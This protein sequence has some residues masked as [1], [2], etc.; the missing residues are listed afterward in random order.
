[1]KNANIV[2]LVTS[3]TQNGFCS[4]LFPVA[5]Y[6]LHE[7]LL[8]S[9]QPYWIGKPAQVVD[10][11]RDLANG[12]H[13]LHNFRPLAKNAEETERITKY[14]YHHDIKPRNI[15]VKGTRLI[16]ADFGLSRLKDVNEDTKT[17]WKNTQP[18]YGAPEA[19]DP[20]TLQERNIGRAYDI[21]SFGCVLSE[22]ATYAVEG[23][24]A[25]KTFRKEREKEGIYGNDN[26]F[27]HDG[28]VSPAVTAWYQKMGDHH[29][30]SSLSLLFEIS[31]KLLIGDPNRRHKSEE[32]VQE[33]DY[34]SLSRW[35]QCVL[36]NTHGASREGL[37]TVYLAKLTLE[38][39]RLQAWGYALG[40]KSFDQQMQPW[41]DQTSDNY[42]R[43][44]EVLKSCTT[45]LVEFMNQHNEPDIQQRVL[46]LL[47]S[48][49]DSLL[50]GLPGS[51]EIT[52]ENTFQLFTVKTGKTVQLLVDSAKNPNSSTSIDCVA[53]QD[54]STSQ[55]REAGLL[56]AARYISLMLT[57]DG[58]LASEKTVQII[59]PSLIGNEPQ[60]ATYSSPLSIRWYY[61]GFR[62]SD[63]QRVVVEER[64][65]DSK[66][67]SIPNEEDFAD[68]GKEVFD[69]VKELAKL[70]Q[71]QP[72]PKDMRVLDCLGVYHL[73]ASTKFGF[74]YE[75]PRLQQEERD[76]EPVSL[77]DLI[78]DTK[79]P[80]RNPTLD[81]KFAL[82]QAIASCIHSLH[83]TGWLHKSICSS[84]LIYFNKPGQNL[85]ELKLPGPYLTGFQ[86]SRQSEPG[87][88]S[89]GSIP[90][91]EKAFIHPSY[92]ENGVGFHSAFD[93]YSLG[94]ILL[95]IA[96]WRPVDKIIVPE[97]SAEKTR[98]LLF[99]CATTYIPKRMGTGY[100]DVVIA[101]LNF[102]DNH[103]NEK[104]ESSLL[105][106]FQQEV[107]GKLQKASLPL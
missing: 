93:Y 42:A 36:S 28:E 107:L 39:N 46:D 74:V 71:M 97:S 99:E 87:A 32:L 61:R 82:S 81:D 75:F 15:L 24:A 77:T 31:S 62:E 27:H 14:G 72:K 4:L 6:D 66:W 5:D 83:L 1:M 78:R 34:A 76:L 35:L 50:L 67:T 30:S 55:H 11:L 44:R 88:Y 25:V 43:V 68:R 89:D 59:D 45:K 41:I 95:E 84:K 92:Q 9:E 60:D 10:S 64:S 48:T 52:I 90:T 8:N 69:R 12:L 29:R 49:N 13:Y 58:S 102:Y 37:S 20:I 80:V 53:D 85:T 38:R 103:I 26:C 101:C 70:F 22:F 96:L 104:K 51:V 106:K 33:F 54:Q 94:V 65:Y 56:A 21:W 17:I 86:H 57:S 79:D 47:T 7:L 2:Q 100:C 98:L 63:K 3:Y 91:Q 105:M 19:C 73:P 40:L 16:L 23:A 18:T